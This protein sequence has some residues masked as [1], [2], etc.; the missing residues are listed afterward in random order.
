MDLA[1]KIAEE[2]IST[3]FLEWKTRPHLTL[4]CFN[5]V[6]EAGCIEKL[7]NFVANHRVMPAYIGSI[8]MFNDTKTIFVSPVMNC[9]MYQFQRELYESLI[10][11]DTSGWEWY[12]PDRWVPHCTIALTGDDEENAFFRASDLLLHSFQKLCGEFTSIGLVKITFPV[13]EIFTADLKR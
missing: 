13:E 9:D 6:N 4:A 8:G 7:K 5:D 10:S 12:C 1:K 2:K 3:K 11:F